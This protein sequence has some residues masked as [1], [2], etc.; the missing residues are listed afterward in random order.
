LY[1][2]KTKDE[3]FSKFQEF[4]AEIE[5]LTSK[6]IKILRT[7]NGGEYTSKEFVA[8]CKS[9]EI[10]RELTV[11]HNPQQNGVAERKYRSIE[12][13]VK[14]L[15]NDQGLPMY[16]WGEAVM[17]TIY[18]QN[19]SPH[20]ILKDMTPEEAFSGK[21]PNVEHLRIFGCHV[22]I[23]ISKDKRKKLEPSGKKGIFVGYSESSKAY[24]IYIP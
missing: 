10:R 21:K 14:G 13:T 22:Y 7:D 12:E 19:K 16:L 15:M 9:A 6:K 1:L 23:H 20:R 17:T 8:F 2:L 3:V 5:N 18:V 24:R 11:P 4:K